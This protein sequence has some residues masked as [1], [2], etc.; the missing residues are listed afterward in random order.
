M[1]TSNINDNVLHQRSSL[2]SSSNQTGNICDERTFDK[3]ENM[4][5]M[6]DFS[7]NSCSEG[8]AEAEPG[9]VSHEHEHQAVREP[10]LLT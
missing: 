2:P 6:S 5:P 10:H 9:V 1:N 3:E 4:K 7:P 8:D